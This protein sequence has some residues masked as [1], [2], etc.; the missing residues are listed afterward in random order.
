MCHNPELETMGSCYDPMNIASCPGACSPA[1]ESSFLGSLVRMAWS[2]NEGS[3]GGF[4][5][6]GESQ[7]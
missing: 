6:G 2:K 7:H 4:A 3:E 5:H 1:Q